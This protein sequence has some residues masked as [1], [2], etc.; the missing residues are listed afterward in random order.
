MSMIT[1]KGILCKIPQLHVPLFSSAHFTT[2]KCSTIGTGNEYCD[3]RFCSGYENVYANLCI[4]SF[5]P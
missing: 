5:T 3:C 2:L 4:Q 1:I